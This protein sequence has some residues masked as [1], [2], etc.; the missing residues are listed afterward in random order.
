MSGEAPAEIIDESSRG[1]AVLTAPTPLVYVH[2]FSE[3]RD[4]A[5]MAMFE[6]IRMRMETSYLMQ[7][8]DVGIAGIP[9]AVTGAVNSVHDVHLGLPMIRTNRN[10][11]NNNLANPANSVGASNYEAAGPIQYGEPSTAVVRSIS[12]FDSDGDV[13]VRY[14]HARLE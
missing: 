1:A 3:N 6:R 14:K 13:T 10:G 9:G 8:T 2:P 5:I 4:V 11:Q 7:S 12:G